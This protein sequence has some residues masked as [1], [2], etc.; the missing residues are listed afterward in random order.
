MRYT[1]EVQ[2]SSDRQRDG[3]WHGICHCDSIGEA[4]VEAYKFARPTSYGRP[5]RVRDGDKIVFSTDTAPAKPVKRSKK[6]LAKMA[7]VAA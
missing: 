6:A 1:V 7:K 2:H 3:I 5:A 4:R